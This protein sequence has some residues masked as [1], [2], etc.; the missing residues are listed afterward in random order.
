M[1]CCVDVDYRERSVLAACVAFTG[2]SA[3]APLLER[4]LATSG[5]APDYEPGAFYRRELPYLLAVLATLPEPPRLV[6]VDGFVWLGTQ[7]LGLGAH[8]HTALAGRCAVVGVAKRPYRDALAIPVQRGSSQQPLFV[9]AV[10][11]E[12]EEAAAGLRAMHGEHRIPTLLKR[13][14]RLSRDTAA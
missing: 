14:D 1:Y 12:L 6:I 4:V 9:S 11:I 10:G 5:P 7:R 13:V 8:L 2:W 3:A